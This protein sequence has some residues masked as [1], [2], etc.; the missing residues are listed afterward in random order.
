MNTALPTT[1]LADLAVQVRNEHLLFEAEIRS[2]LN[3]ARRAGEKLIAAKEQVPHGSFTA[4]V[5]QCQIKPRTARQ[6]MQVARRWP[7]IA[8]LGSDAPSTIQG[9]MKLLTQEPAE[10]E[11]S[12]R[13][14]HAVLPE[15]EGLS[16]SRKGDSQL[17]PPLATLVESKA[18]TEDHGE[19]L[20]R[21]RD[22][23]G[24]N[25]MKKFVLDECRKPF[26]DE[27][28]WGLVFPLR[29]QNRPY[30]PVGVDQL[31]AA[32]IAPC[33][34]F[35]QCVVD[36]G[37]EI[38]QWIG[39]A[40]WWAAWA[41]HF[42]R[43]AEGLAKAIGEWEERYH[44]ALGCFCLFHDKQDESQRKLYWGFHE[45]LKQTTSLERAKNFDREPELA[46]AVFERVDRLG[47]ILPSGFQGHGDQIEPLAVAQ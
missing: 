14:A 37:G 42:K 47:F 17:P 45:D 13:H 6:Y 1:N 26:V 25:L 19:Q 11:D 2:G 12:K 4:F 29:P 21:V 18:L 40:F 3:H 23:L 38:Q 15:F 44:D 28:A 36:Q 32:M 33:R 30:W 9:A 41:I 43:S 34:L 16:A 7:E 5:E 39:T 27:E 31:P 46:R 24:P 35:L 20:L 8:N 10:D 22:I